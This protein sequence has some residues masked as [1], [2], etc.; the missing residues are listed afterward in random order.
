MDEFEEAIQKMQKMDG[1]Q[2]SYSVQQLKGMCICPS[3]PTY[4]S[5]MKEKKER[6]YCVFG[7]ERL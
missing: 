1:D 7:K 2:P 3:C 4:C 6:M 5:C